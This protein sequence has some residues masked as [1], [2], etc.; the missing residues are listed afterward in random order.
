MMPASENGYL[1]KANVMTALK[2]YEEAE[3]IL[4]MGQVKATDCSREY[5]E[6]LQA[7]VFF[8]CASMCAALLSLYA[9]N[10]VSLRV[11]R[12]MRK[13]GGHPREC[14]VTIHNM[15]VM[16]APSGDG[17]EHP[18]K[19]RQGFGGRAGLGGECHQTPD[20]SHWRWHS[21]PA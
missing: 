16:H 3:S 9:V 6:E 7:V 14:P 13:K 5:L 17:Q 11:D 21:T 2:R 10:R 8:S 12:P 18:P 19:G 1:V 15:H 4:K 20:G